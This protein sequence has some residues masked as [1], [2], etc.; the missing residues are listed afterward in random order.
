MAAMQAASVPIHRFSSPRSGAQ[1]TEADTRRRS[2]PWKGWPTALGDDRAR[3]SSSRRTR[4]A[5]SRFL[6]SSRA[7]TL[8][9]DFWRLQLPAGRASRSTTTSSSSTPLLAAAATQRGLIVRA[10]P[11]DDYLDHGVLVPMQLHPR[12]LA[13]CRSRSSATTEVHRALGSSC[14]AAPRSWGATCVFLASGDL[15][16]R[17]TRDA[18]AGYDPQ[19]DVF[20]ARG[21]R[22]C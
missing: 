10:R 1:A 20:D 15:S 22:R 17:L 2:P 21:R 13:S 11:I 12:R 7:E 19:G 9:G 4:R 3:S 8:W 14:G 6:R 16:H 5:T 18:P